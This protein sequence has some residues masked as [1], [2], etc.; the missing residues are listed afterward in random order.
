MTVSVR[1][2]FD[3]NRNWSYFAQSPFCLVDISRRDSFAASNS[4]L[5]Q[6]T[7]G[8]VKRLF[9]LQTEA[10]DWCY[11]CCVAVGLRPKAQEG[12]KAETHSSALDAITELLSA[13]VEEAEAENEVRCD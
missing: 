10:S 12:S 5:R 9:V 13:A 8:C 6:A 2:C 7:L 3:L 4:I 11:C 1:L